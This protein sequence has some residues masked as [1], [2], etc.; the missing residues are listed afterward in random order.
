[1]SPTQR[2]PDGTRHV[3]PTWESLVERQIREAIDEG[4]FDRLPHQGGRLPLDDDA[5]AG[6]WALAYRLLRDNGMAPP[7]IEAD[8]AARAG[9][10]RLAELHERAAT[11]RPAGRGRLRALVRE[12]VADTN[13]WIERLNAEA[14]TVQ[15]HRRPLDLEAE[16]GRL[17]G[18]FAAASA[19]DRGA[20]GERQAPPRLG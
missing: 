5:A 18:S 13:R 10:E 6:E 12:V 9:L 20:R 19:S 2:D 8:K 3:G 7:W 16:L 4:R 1:M 15:Q 11:A 14:P 17:E